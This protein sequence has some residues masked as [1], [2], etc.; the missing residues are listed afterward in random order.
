LADKVLKWGARSQI[1]AIATV[2][3]QKERRNTLPMSH[4][5]QE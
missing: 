3:W 2:D 1:S 4:Q 5:T